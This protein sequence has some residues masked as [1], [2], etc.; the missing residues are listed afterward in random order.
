MS[1][2]DGCNSPLGERNSVTEV[3]GG[4]VSSHYGSVHVHVADL[5]HVMAESLEIISNVS[6]FSNHQM[7]EISKEKRDEQIFYENVPVQQL[8][9]DEEIVFTAILW[10]VEHPGGHERWMIV[11]DHEVKMIEANVLGKVVQSLFGLVVSDCVPAAVVGRKYI[12]LDTT[13]GLLYASCSQ[14]DLLSFV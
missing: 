13:C 6:D 12:V 14:L 5:A 1:W 8:F 10:R 3:H 2:H 7:E 9:V 11:V 4:V